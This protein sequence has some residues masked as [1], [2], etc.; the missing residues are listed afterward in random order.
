MTILVEFW[1][2]MESAVRGGGTCLWETPAKQMLPVF[3]PRIKVSRFEP[4]GSRFVCLQLLSASEQ[5]HP[6][7]LSLPVLCCFFEGQDLPQKVCFCTEA[8]AARYHIYVVT[9]I[10]AK[11]RLQ[12]SRAAD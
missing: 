6:A 5:N 7:L 12:F 11:S 2:M 9:G 1:R 3:S 10:M 8:A 4:K